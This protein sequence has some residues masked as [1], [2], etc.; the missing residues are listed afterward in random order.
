MGTVRESA[1]GHWIV[2]IG[3]GDGSHTRE[4]E[5]SMIK[6]ECYVKKKGEKLCIGLCLFNIRAQPG[7]RGRAQCREIEN[8]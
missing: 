7:G 3:V 5:G 8:F 1:I 2:E 4:N 6:G